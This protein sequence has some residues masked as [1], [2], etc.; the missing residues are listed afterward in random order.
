[1]PASLWPGTAQ[2][3]AYSPGGR[4]TVIVLDSPL[5]TSPVSATSGIVKVCGNAPLLTA[6][7]VTSV[8]AAIVI[9]VGWKA[10]STISTSADVAP[11]SPDWPVGEATGVAPPPSTTVNLPTMP[12]PS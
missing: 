12:A 10:R 9:S 2:S 6:L 5:A 3:N 8:F 1:M 4:L 11:A 7:I